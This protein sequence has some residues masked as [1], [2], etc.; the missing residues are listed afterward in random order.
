[1][2]KVKTVAEL[3]NLCNFKIIIEIST[4]VLNAFVFEL[5]ELIREVLN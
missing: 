4:V 1:M 3:C 5:R 2:K